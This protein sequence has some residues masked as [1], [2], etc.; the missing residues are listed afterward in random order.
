MSIKLGCIIW[1][2][3]LSR[4]NRAEGCCLFGGTSAPICSGDMLPSMGYRWLPKGRRMQYSCRG[5]V[6][7]T[8]AETTR[9][10]AANA[11]AAQRAE[12]RFN[13]NDAASFTLVL[14][15]ESK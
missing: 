12:Y 6:C 9:P 2:C 7:G 14:R 5:Q 8:G 3:F 10:R 15:Q 1:V 11:L 4:P 13:Q